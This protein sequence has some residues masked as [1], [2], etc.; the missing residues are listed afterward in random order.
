MIV[1]TANWLISDG[2]VSRPPLEAAVSAYLESIGRAA[3]RA[4]LRG[5][6]RYQP[7]DEIALVLAG[8]T[9]DRLSS[10]RWLGRVKPWHGWVAR[11]VAEEVDAAILRNGRRILQMLAKRVLHGVGVPSADRRGRPDF[12]RLIRVPV[13]LIV[14]EGDRDTSLSALSV[15]TTGVWPRVI[16]SARL[17]QGR[18]ALGIHFGADAT[19][20]DGESVRIDVAHGH[21]LDPC[22]QSTSD[23]AGDAREVECRARQPTLAESI[24]VDLISRFVWSLATHESPRIRHVEQSLRRHAAR[25]LVAASP[26]ELPDRLEA[27]L[28]GAVEDPR[29]SADGRLEMDAI[30]A[31]MVRDEWCHSVDRWR[32]SARIDEPVGPPGVDIVSALAD[33][34]LRPMAECRSARCRD[35]L[36]I[37]G[38]AL[39]A[40][41]RSMDHA[42]GRTTVIASQRWLILGHPSSGHVDQHS[43]RVILLGG[44][45]RPSKPGV[46]M[47]P[48]ACATLEIEPTRSGTEEFGWAVIDLR[49]ALAVVHRDAQDPGKRAA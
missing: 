28:A 40:A 19:T 26:L 36:C 5:D 42:P 10:R 27:C 14:L 48:Q 23:H 46:E 6:G 38:S 37:D 35:W 24:Q 31:G 45:G 34:F 7:V 9:F 32:L 49:R 43:D 29:D 13:R 47:A 30:T 15:A 44:R 33:H 16:E 22:C 12:V 20:A 2:S 17:D 1:A 21:E 3:V 18:I 11:Q 39:R 25:M 4:G 41:G 8:D